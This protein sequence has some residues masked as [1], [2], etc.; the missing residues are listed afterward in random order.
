MAG[1]KIGG[2]LNGRWGKRLW[3]ILKGSIMMSNG[4][5]PADRAGYLRIHFE[6]RL[7]YEANQATCW[8]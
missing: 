2:L 4:S 7:G 5:C 3:E 8:T 1:A 6:V